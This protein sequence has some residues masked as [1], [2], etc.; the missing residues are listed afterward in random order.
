MIFLAVPLH[1]LKFSLW[2]EF[3]IVNSS[4]SMS[5][6]NKTL[7]STNVSTGWNRST[8]QTHKQTGL[9]SD[10]VVLIKVFIFCHLLNPVF[11]NFIISLIFFSLIYT[12]FML[13]NQKG[14]KKMDVKQ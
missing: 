14:E 7:Y 13:K 12:N 2:W 1:K 3:T 10:I 8:W 5:S 9:L 6:I 11:N 4:F